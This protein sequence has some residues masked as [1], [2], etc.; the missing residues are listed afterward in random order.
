MPN[1]LCQAQ[2]GDGMNLPMLNGMPVYK[3]VL[4][5]LRKRKSC[6]CAGWIATRPWKRG[7]RA[8]CKSNEWERAGGMVLDGKVYIHPK[9]WDDFV[10]AMVQP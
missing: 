7:H 8:A 3:S 1:V 6:D 5:P 4:A 2:S 10:A 9:R